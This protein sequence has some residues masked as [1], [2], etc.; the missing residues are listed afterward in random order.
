MNYILIGIT[1]SVLILVLLSIR[2]Y[3]SK[4]PKEHFKVSAGQTIDIAG[5]FKKA[6]LPVGT[7]V[8]TSPSGNGTAIITID[9]DY[10]AGEAAGKYTYQ[11]INGGTNYA[12]NDTL[13]I[14]GS[15]LGGITTDNDAT[16]KVTGVNA[17]VIDSA[18]M[19]GTPIFQGSCS[20]WTNDAKNCS[21]QKVK[22]QWIACGTGSSI[23]CDD[24]LCCEP[25][26]C[27]GY[28]LTDTSS[29]APLADQNKVVSVRNDE[30]CGTRIKCSLQDC[31]RP[32]N[33]PGLL[34]SIPPPACDDASTPCNFATCCTDNIPGSSI[35]YTGPTTDPNKVSVNAK[36]DTQVVTQPGT[37]ASK[38]TAPTYDPNK[39]SKTKG[40]TEGSKFALKSD[41]LDIKKMLSNLG[42][43]Q[44]KKTLFKP[45]SLDPSKYTP[46][47]S[48]LPPKR[49]GDD[50]DYVLKS[51]LQSCPTVDN[52]IKQY[53]LRNQVRAKIQQDVIYTP[54]EIN[55]SSNYASVI[56]NENK[57]TE[58]N[59]KGDAPK[60][61]IQDP[62]SIAK[63]IF[64][65]N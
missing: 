38:T 15:A 39:E 59:T 36:F 13:V 19:T 41:I 10:S 9:R 60:C 6:T 34:K 4:E 22:S 11:L 44:S 45:N 48:V 43:G 65:D 64:D 42:I 50:T 17:G 51:S 40:A 16:F 28:K 55:L 5:E 31:S 1:I 56:P 57:D 61:R 7:V 58:K 63:Y 54:F 35:F 47:S 8:E 3:F 49:M 2:S 32:N 37:G 53:N 25:L 27:S 18:E 29:Y 12:I 20:I 30:N 24:T 33:V 14:L 23:P 26:T 52:Q 46:K 21:G 62:N